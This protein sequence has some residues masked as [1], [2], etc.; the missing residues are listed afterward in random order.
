MKKYTYKNNKP[1]IF[2]VKNAVGRVESFESFNERNANIHNTRGV[3]RVVFVIR[4]TLRIGRATR[5]GG[6]NAAR[7]VRKQTSFRG[8][9][10]ERQTR[11][12]K[13]HRLKHKFVLCS[14]GIYNCCFVTLIVILVTYCIIQ[15]KKKKNT[16]SA[17]RTTHRTRRSTRNPERRRRR[18]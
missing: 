1:Y 11:K 7:T 14:Y 4:K 3:K 15:K 12:K 17:E 13:S 10:R 18:P 5:G 6:S 16:N 2:L 8:I 9:R